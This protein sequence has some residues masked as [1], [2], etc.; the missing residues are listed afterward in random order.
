MKDYILK[1]NIKSIIHFE[2]L[3]HKAFSR[4]DYSDHSDILKLIYCCYYC[5][6]E[7]FTYTYEAFEKVILN[8]QKL[9]QKVLNQFQKVVQLQEQF[10]TKSTVSDE[11]SLEVH[12][13]SELFIHKV[14]PILTT[15]CGLDITYILNEMPLDDVGSY[16]NYYNSAKQEE[17][18]LQRL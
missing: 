14:I 4:L 17:L 9:S 15:H 3:A 7:E 1:L 2:K 8:N 18:Q 10:S 12:Q 5:N 13:E 11:S 16:I 6:N